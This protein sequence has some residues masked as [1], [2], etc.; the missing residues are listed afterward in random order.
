MEVEGDV[1]RCEEQGMAVKFT[2][3]DV[4][5]L[6]HLK[7]LIKVHAKDPETI[8]VEYERTLLEVKEPS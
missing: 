8:A 5:S 6:I 4:D 3:I 2:R 7:H 1:V